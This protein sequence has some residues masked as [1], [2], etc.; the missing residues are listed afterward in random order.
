L[1]LWQDGEPQED[2]FRHTALITSLHTPLL[3][4]CFR[5]KRNKSVKTYKSLRF[6]VIKMIL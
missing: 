3:L 6:H 4:F 1:L 2:E 5:Y